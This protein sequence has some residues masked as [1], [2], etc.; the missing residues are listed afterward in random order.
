VPAD[1]V[2]KLPTVSAGRKPGGLRFCGCVGILNGVLLTCGCQK[3][4][5]LPAMSVPAGA[6]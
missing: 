3:V 6:G 2:D 1:K 5:K 4:D